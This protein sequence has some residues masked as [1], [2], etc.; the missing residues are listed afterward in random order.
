MNVQ[1]I[2]DI[3][4]SEIITVEPDAT[5]REMTRIMADRGIG[6]V[7]VTDAGGKLVGIV[8]ERD[9]VRSIADRGEQSFSL[10]AGDLMTRSLITCT[11]ET[12]IADAL[13]PMSRNGIRHLPVIGNDGIVGLISIRDILNHR[14]QSLESDIASLTLAAEEVRQAKEKA[15]ISDRAKTEF[16]ANMSHELKTP[17]NAVIGFSE[18][19]AGEVLGPIGTPQ[20]REYAQEICASGRHLAEIVNDILDV[21]RLEANAVEVQDQHIRIEHIVASSLRLVTDRARESDI[22]LSVSVP[23]DLPLLIADQRMIKQMVNNLLTNAVKFT[24]HGGKVSIT[25]IY[26]PEGGT[27]IAVRDNGCGIPADML[28]KVTLPFH[29]ADAS[30]GRKHEGTGL[31]LALVNSMM[32]LHGGR[33]VL[34]SEPGAGTTAILQFPAER[35]ARDSGGSHH[36][37]TESR[38]IA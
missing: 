36:E 28:D 18:M 33:L 10:C 6:T 11:R 37:P 1:D 13:A 38:A 4:G 8:S 32:S 5:I 24:P 23:S 16:L 22:L 31:G 30:L 7:L 12:S 29:Q 15:E 35:V 21:S 25:S 19:M 20:Y 26:T 27:E 17:L 14:A 2:L 9:I 3:K 34:E